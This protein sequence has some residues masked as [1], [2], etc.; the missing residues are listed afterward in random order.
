MSEL[1]D[2]Q[3]AELQIL[4]DVA[5]VCEEYHIAYS[6]AYGSL[7]GAV[8]HKGFIPWDDDV[9]ILMKADDIERFA[10]VMGDEYKNLYFIQTPKAEP[11]S[12]RIHTMVRKNGT[13]ML[14]KSETETD[15]K[16]Q[17]IGIDIFPVIG[18]SNN[19]KIKQKQLD[20]LLFY[21][22]LRYKHI[23]NCDEGN[24]AKKLIKRIK[25]RQIRIQESRVWSRVRRMGRDEKN[26]RCCIVGVQFAKWFSEETRK[27]EKAVCPKKLLWDGL[28]KYPFEDTAFYGPEDYD[29]VLKRFYG[30][31]YMTP[32]KYNVHVED[33][34]K[35]IL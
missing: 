17:G 33:Y 7:L 27:K 15:Q 26:T 5:K 8:R 16:N 23:W 22:N 10:K 19:D 12:G 9:D 35:V 3:A 21:Q 29:G 25:E 32:R 34:S 4:K 20:L 13:L 1:K 2:L 24:P 11:Y 30:D 31:D 18:I 6:L 14:T 28:R